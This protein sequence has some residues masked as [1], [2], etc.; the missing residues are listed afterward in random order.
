MGE[1]RKYNFEK[2][3]PLTS[4]VLDEYLEKLQIEVD[5]VNAYQDPF[6]AE[7]LSDE[8]FGIK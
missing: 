1:V 8:H 3:G 5:A 7:A 2:S 4:E 6:G